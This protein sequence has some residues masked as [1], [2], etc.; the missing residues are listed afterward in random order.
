MSKPKV[1][2][3]WCASCGGCEEAT[4]DLTERLF[5]LI[6]AVDIVFWP[7]AMDFKREDLEKMEDGSI[8]IAIINGG[9]RLEEHEEIVTEGCYGILL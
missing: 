9:I 8:D 2:L 7:I 5:D 6:E 1:A 3:Y 4:V